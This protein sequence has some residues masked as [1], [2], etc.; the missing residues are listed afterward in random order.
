MTKTGTTNLQTKDTGNQEIEKNKAK[1]PR[2]KK[3]RAKLQEKLGTN[4]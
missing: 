4:K 2:K 3:Q 1:K